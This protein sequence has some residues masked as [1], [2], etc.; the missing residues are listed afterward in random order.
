MMNG[1]EPVH[2][3]AYMTCMYAYVY[4]VKDLSSLCHYEKFTSICALA[5]YRHRQAALQ[6]MRR[7][8]E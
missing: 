3:E 5:H 1:D 6:R 2:V 4:I 7:R 8:A